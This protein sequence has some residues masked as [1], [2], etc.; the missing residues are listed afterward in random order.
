MK[1][2]FNMSAADKLRFD[3]I[4]DPEIE[5][6]K[7]RGT[8]DYENLMKLAIDFSD[9]VIMGS[10][11][12]EPEVVKYLKDQDTLTLPYEEDFDSYADKINAFYDK[13]TE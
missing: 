8:M 10:D 9:G 4:G 2:P 13:I 12:V 5:K 3:G 6:V 1:K 11:K 7:S